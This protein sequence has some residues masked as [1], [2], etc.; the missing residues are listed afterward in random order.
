MIYPVDSA[1]QRLNNWSQE[2]CYHGNVRNGFSLLRLFEP[3]SSLAV[4]QSSLLSPVTFDIIFCLTRSCNFAILWDDF[5]FNLVLHLGQNL[6]CY[7]SNETSEGKKFCKFFSNPLSWTDYFIRVRRLKRLDTFSSM[8][9]YSN[10]STQ[11]TST[12]IRIWKRTFDVGSLLQ[13]LLVCMTVFQNCNLGEPQ[14]LAEYLNIT[15]LN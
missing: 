15:E 12:G 3:I 13:S 2:F 1:I 14:K 4:F 8:P 10:V 6:W 5:H 11:T 9:G 7:H